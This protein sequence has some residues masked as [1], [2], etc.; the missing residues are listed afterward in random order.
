MNVDWN[1]NEKLD[2]KCG[3]GH[4]IRVRF[5]DVRRKPQVDVT[6]PTCQQ[7]VHIRTD[8]FRRKLREVEQTL[9]N[10]GNSR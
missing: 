3:N 10:F 9:R 5:G 8:D 6:C 1:D 2:F 7:K 4:Q